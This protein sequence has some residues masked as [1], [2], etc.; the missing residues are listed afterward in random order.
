MQWRPQHTLPSPLESAVTVMKNI[1]KVIKPQGYIFSICAVNAESPNKL[2]DLPLQ[3]HIDDA[4]VKTYANT[5]KL[6]HPSRS[7]L[8]MKEALETLIG[9]RIS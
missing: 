6:G 9:R 4:S 1:T 8:K 5:W 3:E 2:A 7:G